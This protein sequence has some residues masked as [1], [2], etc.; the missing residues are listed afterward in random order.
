MTRTIP[1]FDNKINVVIGE[2]LSKADSISK[3]V[4]DA[5]DPSKDFSQNRSLLS[6][7]RYSRPD[8]ETCAKFL[9]VDI[10]DS[11]GRILF[12][13]K[14]SLANRIILQVMLFYPAICAECD[15]EYSVKFGSESKP[16][17]HCFLCFQGSHDCNE[18]VPKLGRPPP[19]R[20]TIWL[21]KSVMTITTQLS[22][23]CHGRRPA[24]KI[25]IATYQG[26]ATHQG[27]APLMY[28]VTNFVFRLTMSNYGTSWRNFSNNN[29]NK[30]F[31]RMFQMQMLPI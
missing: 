8:L 29:P 23:P 7:A 28:K 24:V 31:S 10:L 25:R 30:R 9:L 16:A 5:F 1:D 2:L 15:N 19:L 20:G 4:I 13:N 21:C 12:S 17:L 27:R 3:K 26:R 6:S 22:P 14:V 11:K 18:L